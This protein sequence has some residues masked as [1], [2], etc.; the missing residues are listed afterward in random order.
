MGKHATP[1]ATLSS[2]QLSAFCAQSA[3]LL[4]AGIPLY[5][6]GLDS[7]QA[8]LP[9]GALRSALEAVTASVTQGQSFSQALH[10]CPAF[11]AYLAD[12]V[13][14][15]EE[16]GRTDDVLEGL[17][18]H[19]QRQALNEKRLRSAVFYPVMLIAMM[20]VVVTILLWKVLPT[21]EQVYRQLGGSAA[22]FG[23]G[24][25]P[26][27]LGVLYTLLV[28]VGV[29]ILVSRTRR[30]GAWLARRAE[31]FAPTRALSEKM[32]LTRVASSL[33][34]LLSS[35]ID[36][37]RALA[38]T[39]P[40][41]AHRSVAARLSA[42]AQAMENGQGFGEALQNTRLF[43]ALGNRF[44]L[45]GLRTGA[46]DKALGKVAQLYDEDVTD[47]LDRLIS[48]TEPALTALLAV[49]LGAVLLSVMLPLIRILSAIG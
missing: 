17:S 15:G 14:L 46:L 4:R 49:I 22:S 13:A 3:M 34:L 9:A 19:Y 29:L 41:V 40:L 36:P 37:A 24:W 35:G 5:G 21:F 31:T 27:C 18:A 1:G 28:V 8:D 10:A 44:A 39:Q 38:L 43:T 48:L 6:G 42:C 33:S 32:A 30:G 25:V 11:P 23:T 16:S 26:A 12:T 20:A 47:T 2:A 7:L 45:L